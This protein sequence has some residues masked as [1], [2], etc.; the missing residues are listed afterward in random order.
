[1]SIWASAAARRGNS[2]MA[3][4]P[5]GD[6]AIWTRT[7][8]RFAHSLDATT[9]A[10]DFG[11]LPKVASDD[12]DKG[13]AAELLAE[14]HE[15][16]AI[17][18]FGRSGFEALAW[19]APISFFGESQWGIYFH[20]PRFWGFCRNLQ[21][22]LPNSTLLGIA[23][24]VYRTLDQHE[25]FHAATELFSLIAQDHSNSYGSHFGPDL[26]PTYFHNHYLPTWGQRSCIEESLATAS[27][28]TIRLKVP[29]LQALLKQISSNSI[30][31]YRDWG[32]YSR[33]RDF[34]KGIFELSATKI[35]T[36]TP[37]GQSHI[38]LLLAAAH[39][40]AFYPEKGWWFPDIRIPALD[41]LGPIPR[42]AARQPGQYTKLFPPAILGSYRMR[43]L[44]K[45]AERLY[46]ARLSKGHRKHSKQLV[47]P[48]N[49]VVP[50]PRDREVPHYVIKEI[51]A[52]VNKPKQEVLRDLGCL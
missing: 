40:G 17:E 39:A 4:D 47:F 1:M 28:F 18:S 37:D 20:E 48:N 31:G 35:I 8:S 51:A 19:Y 6:R 9:D 46:G 7:A 25:A 23:K 2:A 44:P 14:R 29:G 45:D 36:G 42:Y 24:D 49:V 16:E 11:E 15:A 41:R 50:L 26:Y 21:R 3:S 32:L 10:E 13:V 38:S 33:K 5:W 43:N 27:Q 30:G 34:A 22:Q 12:Q 52:A